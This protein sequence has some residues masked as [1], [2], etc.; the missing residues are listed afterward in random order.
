MVL[1][2][3]G[4]FIQYSSLVSRATPGK[5]SAPSIF[6]PTKFTI[7]RSLVTDREQ[8]NGAGDQTA[9]ENDWSTEV[10]GTELF[11]LEYNCE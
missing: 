5:F 1:K 9:P 2:I 11:A 10:R 8:D 4:H 6:F 7:G 3:R